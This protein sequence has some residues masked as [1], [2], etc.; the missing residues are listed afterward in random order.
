MVAGFAAPAP[1]PGLV[2]DRISPL[3]AILALRRPP[4]PGGPAPGVVAPA[5]KNGPPILPVGRGDARAKITRQ[6]DPPAPAG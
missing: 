1:R 3:A 6:G 2:T 4:G 5:V